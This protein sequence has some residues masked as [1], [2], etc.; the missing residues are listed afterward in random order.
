MTDVTVCVPSIPPRALPGG[1]LERALR[2]VERQQLAP[3]EVIVEIDGDRTGAAATRQRALDRV[4]TEFV[5]FLDD[6]DVLLPHHLAVLRREMDR[7]ETETETRPDL[8][9]DLVYP[10]FTVVGGEDPFP[11]RFGA[12]FDAIALRRAQFVPITVL[13]RTRAVLDAGGFRENPTP[14]GWTNEDH[15]LWLAMLDRGCTF[16]HLPAKTWI[17]TH[18]ASNTSGRRDLW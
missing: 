6:D 16:R 1:M 10:W 11:G 18:H 13:A 3:R 15:T 8:R 2:S 5:A 4:T 12:D 14:E 17:W 9:P 7:P